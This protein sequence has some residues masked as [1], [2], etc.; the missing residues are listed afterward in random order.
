MIQKSE[1]M[2]FTP[3][4]HDYMSLSRFDGVTVCDPVTCM[5]L[6]HLDWETVPYETEAFMSVLDTLM[7]QMFHVIEWSACLSLTP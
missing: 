1:C 7:G 5:S 6:W 3:W 4:Q 2:S